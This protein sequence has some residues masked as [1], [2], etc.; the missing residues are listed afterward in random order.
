MH[1]GGDIRRPPLRP[2][3]MK[4]MHMILLWLLGSIALLI[5]ALLIYLAFAPR[6]GSNPRGERLARI[7]GSPNYKAGKFRNLVETE[8]DIPLRKMPGLL[9]SFTA[10]GKGRVPKDT[11][12]TVELDRTAWEAIPDSAF[13]VAWFGHSSVLIKMGGTTFLVDPVFGER[14]STFS[15]AGPKR[16]TYRHHIRVDELPPVDVVLLSHD[17]YDHL[18]HVTIL[19]LKNKRFIVP[20]GVGAH[21]EAWGVP[22]S[23]ITE[24][25]WWERAQTGSVAL[26]LAPARHFSGR[27]LNNRFST[28]WGSW[29]LEAA[30]R[31]VYFG[32]DSG[33]SPTFKE[34]GKRF[35]PIDLALLE[36]GAYNALWSGI[37]MFPEQ[38]AQ[39]AADLGA[40]VLM[41]VHWGKFSLAMHPWKEPVERLSAKAKELGMPLLTPRI[42]AV[43]VDAD[44]SRSE[45]WWQG[46]E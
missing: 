25:D 23:A 20:L 8:M 32:A 29:M 42:G 28:L 41:P 26:T 30:G 31:K 14:A 38:T 15:F 37:H 12:P 17:H 21:L 13:A 24:M 5:A 36:C 11:L 16:F 34:V 43:V 44:L 33:Y 27:G 10:G 19:K 9:W 18:D 39:A 22:A 3:S 40:R 6:I 35:G 7:Q 46:L 2:L 1:R 4:R 45:F